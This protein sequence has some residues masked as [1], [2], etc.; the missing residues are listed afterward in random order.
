MSRRVLLLGLLA[1]A[2]PELVAL[3]LPLAA[4]VVASRRGD[5]HELLA[6]TIVTVAIAVP[7]SSHLGLRRGLRLARSSILALAGRRHARRAQAVPASLCIVA[8]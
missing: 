7:S 5:W 3:F 1:H 2:V 8:G 4:W 6:A